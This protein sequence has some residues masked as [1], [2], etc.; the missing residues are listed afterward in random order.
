ME[1]IPTYGHRYGVV[2]WLFHR[3]FNPEVWDSIHFDARVIACILLAWLFMIG[4]DFGLTW[5]FRA[6]TDHQ[7]SWRKVL[8]VDMLCEFTSCVTPSAVGGSALGMVYLNREGIE[9]GRATTLMMTTL[10][11]DEFFFVLSIPVIML[12]G[13][14]QRTFSISDTAVLPWAYSLC[15]GVSMR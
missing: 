15:S 3:E 12:L 5:R 7:L 11:L 14:L 10:F 4:R 2:M 13:A 6:L 9:F 8:K 1:N